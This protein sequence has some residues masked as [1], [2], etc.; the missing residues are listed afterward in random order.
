MK[1][2]ISGRITGSK[3]YRERFSDAGI[4]LTCAGYSF[5]SPLDFGSDKLS[6][7]DNMRRAL[8]IMLLLADGVALLDDW[9]D[10]KGAKIEKRLAEESGVPVKPLAERL[11][12][13]EK[14]RA[15]TGPENPDSVPN[16]GNQKNDR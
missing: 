15:K 5:I 13:P 4:F 16:T 12:E 11:H 6:W 1:I 14:H 2:Y 9:E 10:S 3:F 8:S 7:E